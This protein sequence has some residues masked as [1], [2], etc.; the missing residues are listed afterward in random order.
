MFNINSLDGE[1]DEDT[2]VGFSCGVQ[3]KFLLK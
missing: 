1:M 3:S 2:M